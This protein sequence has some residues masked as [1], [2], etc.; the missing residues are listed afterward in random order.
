MLTKVQWVLKLK[1]RV[2]P[3][4]SLPN[5]GHNAID[6]IIRYIQKSKKNMKILKIMIINIH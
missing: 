4:S 6:D 1:L 5:L 2:L 3:H